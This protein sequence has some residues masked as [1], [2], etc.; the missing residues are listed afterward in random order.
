MKAFTPTT[1]SS[2]PYRV[3][4]V[5]DEPGVLQ[6][7]KT[8]LDNYGFWTEQAT[9]GRE[10]L[11]RLQ[12][13]AFDVVVSDVHMPRYGGL[14]FLR[15]VRER[16][17]DVPVILMTGKP[18]AEATNVAL[19]SGA[20]RCLTKPVMPATLR[21]TIERAVSAHGVARLERR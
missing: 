16:G 11:E 2:V 12:N 7:F 19:R 13:G 3:L 14:D 1:K 5:D 20:F 9:N 8:A 21:E 6:M 15:A 18:S 4:L 17:L 10:G